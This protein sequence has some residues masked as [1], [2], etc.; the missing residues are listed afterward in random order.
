MN[1][2]IAPLFK[3]I[4][5]RV[6]DPQNVEDRIEMQKIVYLLQESG[7]PIGAYGFKWGQKGPFSIHLIDDIN[8]VTAVQ[9]KDVSFS[10]FVERCAASIKSIIEQ[11]PQDISE[12]AW[13][14]AI[15]SLVYLSK[16]VMSSHAGTKE[17]IEEFMKRRQEFKNAEIN[18]KAMSVA[19]TIYM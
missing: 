14:D 5:G 8:S 3:K 7:A 16:Y 4:T 19:K 10:A 15:S 11:K 6:F 2:Y 13:L 18:R 12:L 9:G 17:V 1:R